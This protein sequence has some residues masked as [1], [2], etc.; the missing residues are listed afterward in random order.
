MLFQ[1]CVAARR[2]F[3]RVGPA[4]ELGHDPAGIVDILERLDDCAIVEV[5]RCVLDLSLGCTT[6]SQFQAIADP[7]QMV[8]TLAG[9]DCLALTR[10]LE[11]LH[12][13]GRAS[14]VAA[15]L[16]PVG[17]QT[18][19][20]SSTRREY[21][22]L[23]ASVPEVYSSFV[24]LEVTGVPSRPDVDQL[25]DL[26]FTVSAMRPGLT[27]QSAFVNWIYVRQWNACCADLASCRFESC[28]APDSPMLVWSCCNPHLLRIAHV[29]RLPASNSTIC[30]RRS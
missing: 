2:P 27:C 6:L 17:Y 22:K 16:V 19:A 24:K 4:I 10:A 25:N 3:I 20:R 13:Y 26:I 7:D 11:M 14:N 30:P 29:Y 23:L 5:N 12:R 1:E 9:M 28:S 15:V 21:L 8:D 18:L